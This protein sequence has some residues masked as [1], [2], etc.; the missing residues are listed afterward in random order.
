MIKANKKG[1]TPSLAKLGDLTVS[2]ATLSKT[3]T[4]VD[5]ID[6]LT[7]GYTGL[8][9]ITVLPVTAAIDSNIVAENIVVGKTILGVNGSNTSEE[10]LT[11]LIDGLTNVFNGS[12][13]K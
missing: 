8:N 4:K 5:L 11:Y 10:E 2:P 1:E 13:V 9:S 12:E 6:Y 7:E 3:Y